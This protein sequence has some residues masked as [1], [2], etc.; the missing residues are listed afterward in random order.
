MHFFS[1]VATLSV[2]FIVPLKYFPG[3][4]VFLSS[5][6]TLNGVY[7]GVDIKIENEGT[8]KNSVLEP[9][10]PISMHSISYY[11]KA[12]IEVP[13]RLSSQINNFQ[14]HHCTKSSN[15][16]HCSELLSSLIARRS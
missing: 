15:G 10:R 8:S 3:S 14:F 6:R 9:P 11:A 4:L 12:S 16:V 2:T 5:E 13:T 7:G 1:C